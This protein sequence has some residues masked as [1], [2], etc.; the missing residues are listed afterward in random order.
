MPYEE[1]KNNYVLKAID[2]ACRR[3]GVIAKRDASFYEWFIHT[4]DETFKELVRSLMLGN[5]TYL[6]GLLR[7]EDPYQKAQEHIQTLVWL[8]GNSRGLIDK[9][10]GLFKFCSFDIPPAT[11]E[12]IEGIEYRRDQVE[13]IFPELLCEFTAEFIQ[14]ITKQDI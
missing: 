5:A 8:V 10:D 6:C 2:D 9:N 1:L 11:D 13:D 4:D 3:K 7:G 12:Q 14:S